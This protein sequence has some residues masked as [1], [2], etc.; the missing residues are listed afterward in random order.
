MGKVVGKKNHP[1][2]Y[3]S[4]GSQMQIDDRCRRP[5]CYMKRVKADFSGVWNTSF[6]LKYGHDNNE[7]GHQS[8]SALHQSNS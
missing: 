1:L 7:L 4:S 2:L 3:V 8:I 6:A 5:R